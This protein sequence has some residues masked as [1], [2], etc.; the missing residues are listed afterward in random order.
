MELHGHNPKKDGSV[1][2]VLKHNLEY[3]KKSR[4]FA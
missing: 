4:L 2:E 3:L 1:E